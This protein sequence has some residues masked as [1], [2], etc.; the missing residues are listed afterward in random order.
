LIFYSLQ[1]LRY[2]STIKLVN[3]YVENLYSKEGLDLMN[4]ILDMLLKNGLRPLSFLFE[5]IELERKL[6][7]SD[8]IALLMLYLR[9]EM[10]MSKL[11]E[12]LGIPLSTTTSLAK[13]L[14]H[15]GLINRNPSSEDK[16]IM[17][18]QLTPEG[19]KIALHLN[20]LIED[21]IAR[22]QSSLTAEELNQ[23]ISLVIKIGKTLQQKDDV[24]AVPQTN[25]SRIIKIDD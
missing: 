17:L 24:K 2:R 19:E 4:Q 25:Q 18:V 20:E 22:V 10:T 14:V 15:K 5:S 6:N 7:R 16:R 9:G 1:L 3:T 8:L 23:F 12:Y 21:I 13:R 11:A